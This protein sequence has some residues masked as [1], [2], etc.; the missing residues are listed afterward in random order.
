MISLATRVIET[1]RGSGYLRGCIVD[2]VGLRPSLQGRLCVGPL[3]PHILGMTSPVGPSLFDFWF[4]LWGGGAAVC[5]TLNGRSSVDTRG[6]LANSPLLAAAER[7]GRVD[8]SSVGVFV[9]SPSL[10]LSLRP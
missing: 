4:G 5:S 7:G 3:K 10:P 9:L 1:L 2:H 6:V 8:P